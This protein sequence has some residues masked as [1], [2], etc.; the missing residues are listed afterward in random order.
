MDD[1]NTKL[2]WTRLELYKAREAVYKG[3]SYEEN[4]INNARWMELEN[5]LAFLHKIMNVMED[6]QFMN[7]QIDSLV[8]DIV[9]ASDL[10]KVLVSSHSRLVARHAPAADIAYSQSALTREQTKLSDLNDRWLYLLTR[11]HETR[12]RLA[13]LQG[14]SD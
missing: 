10:C 1:I 12:K 9:T 4:R 7:K 6:I 11:I 5:R 13:E 3:G 8:I 2:A 14:G